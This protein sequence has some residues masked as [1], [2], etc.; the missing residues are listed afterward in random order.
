MMSNAAIAAAGYSQNPLLSA[1][2][3]LQWEYKPPGAA[4]P[5]ITGASA[6]QRLLR[7]LNMHVVYT[8][9][10]ALDNLGGSGVAQTYGGD[11][12]KWSNNQIQG[13]GN[14]D[15]STTVRIDS[16]KTSSNGR[17]YY[18]NRLITFSESTLGKHIEKLQFTTGTTRS[19]YWYFAQLLKGS[20]AF[21]SPLYNLTTGD[22][23]GI[24]AGAFYTVFVPDS[25]SIKRAVVD[26][27]LPGTVVGG[28][29][30]PN[31]APTLPAEQAQVTNFILYHIL[32]KNAVGTDGSTANPQGAQGGLQT[33]Y[34]TVAGPVT[35]FVDRSA[36]GSL[37]L[38]DVAS[39]TANTRLSAPA[40][41]DFLSNRAV[42][43]SIDNY[44]R[45]Q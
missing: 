39:R 11:Y 18:V 8:P 17:V 24:N 38:R 33:L 40:N 3:T 27:F 15:S 4:A 26:G 45:Y 28:I 31:L 1:D 23:N 10:N 34:I 29:G 35:I 22:I 20:A 36:V 25:N 12:I 41:G 32:D 7:L 13:A 30:V 9:T 44:L 16:F 5:T 2:L 21:A 43:L 19:Q 42:I 6:Y 37:S 14:V